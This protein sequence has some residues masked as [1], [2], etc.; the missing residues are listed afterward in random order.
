M[1][2]PE[3]TALETAKAAAAASGYRIVYDGRLQRIPSNITGAVPLDTWEGVQGPKG[4]P[5]EYAFDGSHISA[6]PALPPNHGL[7]LRPKDNAELLDVLR[8][9]VE[10]RKAIGQEKRFLLGGNI[11]GSGD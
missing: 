1:D 3:F 4:E 7:N 6:R 5:Y 2:I 10:M 9:A 8:R 11:E